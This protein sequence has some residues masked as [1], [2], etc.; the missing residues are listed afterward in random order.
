MPTFTSGADTYTVSAAGTYSLD[1]L[2]GDDRLNVYGGTNVTAHM[3]LGNDL[4]ILKAALN[5]IYGD[6]GLDRFDV[7][8]GGAVIDGGAD[9]D[10]INVRANVDL[11]AHGGLGDDRFNFYAD[12]LNVTLYGDDNNDDFYGYNHTISGSLYGGA[13][14]DYF[15]Q[16][17]NFGGQLILL[18][19]GTGNDVYRA[20]ASSPATFIEN[21]LEGT[22]T[23]QVA[24]GA[25]YTLPANIENISVQGFSGSSAGTAAT[26]T[27]NVLN[28]SIAAH[29][30]IE[31][32][33]GME[34]N[35][36]LSAK[37]GDDTLYGGI[38]NDYLD[39]GTGN[40]TI[41]GDAGNDTLQGRTGNDTMSGGAGDDIYYIDGLFND[42][43]G[44]NAAEGIDTVRVSGSDFTYTVPDNVENAILNSDAS[45]VVLEGSLLD[46]VFSGNAGDDTLRGRDGNDTL[47][48]GNG[49]DSLFGG[50]D[51][52]NLQGGA[53]DDSLYGGY[54][55]DT[56]SGGDGNDTL[57]G[58]QSIEAGLDTLIGGGGADTLT[59]GNLGDTFTYLTISDSSPIARDSITDFQTAA[60]GGADKIDLSAIDANINLAGNQA[61]TWKTVPSAAG[62]LWFTSDGT[63]IFVNADV[64]GDQIAD[65]Q[66]YVANTAGSFAAADIVM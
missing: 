42:V 1:M 61:F 6:A 58:D 53:G 54:G 27:G 57:E 41:Q 45:N 38:G 40:D 8:I 59:G 34:G 16:F 43:V 65:I 46:N 7:Y 15:V 18:H 5:T 21:A 33:Y 10:T 64:D 49:N 2:A 44:E 13:G 26:L 60:S 3:G 63:N 37:G 36:R 29:N 19:G 12:A 20:D 62:D 11:T 35:D 31:T 25:S 50:F 51:D 48:G 55:S 17:G 39:G 32:I 66:I 4:V 23:V 24:R 14:N 52:D 47:R 56:L 22:D 28:N 9:S 30:N